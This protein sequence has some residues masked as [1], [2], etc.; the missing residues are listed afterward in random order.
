MQG[1]DDEPG[2][3]QP[4]D[5]LDALQQLSRLTTGWEG[6]FESRVQEVL[7]L[8]CRYLDLEVG[9]VAT[10]DRGRDR[11]EVVASRG[12]DPDLQTGTTAPLAETFCRKTLDED[13]PLA[14]EDVPGSWADDP[15]QARWNLGCYLGE[16]LV[17]DG[18]LLGTLCFADEAPRDRSFSEAERTFV[19]L[20]A[21][22]VGHELERRRYREELRTSREELASL[23]ERS[24]TLF[25]QETRAEVATAVVDAAR[26]VL[27]HDLVAV[28][29]HDPED[30][31][32]TPVA[33][34]AAADELVDSI[35]T[36]EDEPLVRAPFRAG[37]PAVYDD[38]RGRAVHDYGPMRA[39]MV[40]PLGEDGLLTVGATEVGA[41][42]DADARKAGLLGVVAGATL[43]RMRRETDLN[44]LGTVVETTEEMVFAIDGENRFTVVSPQIAA[45]LGYD[46]ETL[47]GT[48]ATDVLAPGEV[49]F[50]RAVAEAVREDPERSH[51]TF[52]TTVEPA[53]GDAF[54]IRV[55]VSPIPDS[56]G[57]GLVGAVTD[58]TELRATRQELSDERDRFR[59]LFENIPDPVVDVRF[60]DESKPIV[61]TV[62]PAFERV[63]GSE[64]AAIA[65]RD[66]NDVIVPRGQGE[67]AVDLDRRSAA[68]KRNDAE[69]RR[70]AAAGIRDFLLRGIPYRTD[71][72]VGGF[73]IYTDITERK[74][75]ERRLAVLRRVLRHNI[76]NDMNVVMGQAR[77]LA[78]EL[79]DPT[80][81]ERAESIERYAADLVDTSEEAR[82]IES[83]LDG[84][85]AETTAVDLAALVRDVV[86][87][88]RAEGADS[89]F[90]VAV[91]D[92]VSVAAGEHLEL[93]VGALL[94]NAVEHGGEDV[95]VEV[96]V[97]ADEQ[98]VELGV[99][100]DGPGIPSAERNVVAG[101]RE[102]SQLEHG[103]GLGLWL[104]RWVVESYGGEVDIEAADSGSV[105]SIRLRRADAPD[106][107]P[108]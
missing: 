53:T 21:S 16:R 1:A 17:V 65:G 95:T 55:E 86:R 4:R 18:T 58:I 59:Y 91:P 31:R 12:D 100:D 106:A 70:E 72:T 51:E 71:G 77:S 28:H 88:Q 75:R 87:E 78:D 46:R 93:A 6:S 108:T 102:I 81:R 8:G 43:A 38:V 23:L 24:R 89:R 61:E 62:N 48:D 66:L 74:R 83:L 94:E 37:E 41:F 76:R 68:G 2:E 107:D 49:E 47:R 105:V 103:S 3:R 56:E 98:W 50:A 101:S 54:P 97:D 39:A 69:V 14:V 67:S 73:G 60:D 19:E 79:D 99:A 85:G 45:R 44:R 80:L 27:G 11:F 84:D 35:P 82:A 40:V 9:F 10:V 13:G 20:A 30:G 15:A 26:E 7:T 36:Y 52:E 33:R 32:F 104:V 57:G 34:S 29:D 22:A 5:H 92:G 25:D 42:D 90:E 64:A 63:F 96:S